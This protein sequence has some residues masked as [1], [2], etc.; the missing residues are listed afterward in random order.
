M[1]VAVIGA[2]SWGTA[3][4]FLLGEKGLSVALWARGAESAAAI[5]ADRCNRRYLP[6]V[7]LPETV[8]VTADLK[9]AAD[10]AEAVVMVIPSHAMRETA[11]RL[12]GFIN[13]DTL[14]ISAAKGLE[15][16]SLKRMSEVIAEEMPFAADNIVALSGP[17]HA[18]E[19]GKRKPSATVV[20]S[21][22][23]QAAEAAQELFICPY[24]RVYT[25]PDVAGV[26]LGGALK[27]II[28]LG[29]GISDGLGCGDNARAA[30]MTRGLAEIARLGMALESQA[31]TFAGLAGI[32]DLI[33]TC[34]SQH[35][36]NRRAG[37]LLAQGKSVRELESSIN[38]VVEGVRSTRAAYELSLRHG[39]EMPI[40]AQIHQ[41]LYEG[42]SPRDAVVKLMTRSRTHEME[43]VSV[44]DKW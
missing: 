28:A 30:L 26:E 40:T 39:V 22:S 42:T 32:G 16:Q 44:I 4:A 14:V 29:A 34:T 33:V 41:V 37:L 21:A 38:M 23:R 17:N 9:Q 35:S 2:G 20:A 12:A 11:A 18:E 24:L 19:V 10:G 3:L 15:I 31:P 5:D 27:N 36:R 13:R 25:N 1:K 8:R 7:T 6:D 43:E